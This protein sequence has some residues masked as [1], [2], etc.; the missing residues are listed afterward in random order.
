[1]LVSVIHGTTA[2][3]L[4][5]NISNEGR[6]SNIN[7]KMLWAAIIHAKQTGC[8]YFDLGG[9]NKNTPKGISHFK[10]GLRGNNYNLI[11]GFVYLSLFNKF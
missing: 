5:G 2:T 6:K 10:S 3:Y 1:M 9:I 4:I 8:Q 7:Y 11:N